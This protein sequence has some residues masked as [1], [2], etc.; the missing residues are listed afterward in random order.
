M[1]HQRKLIIHCVRLV[2]SY[3]T[4]ATLF[5]SSRCMSVWVCV[6]PPALRSL[7]EVGCLFPSFPNFTVNEPLFSFYNKR[8]M[9]TRI[10]T[11]IMITLHVCAVFSVNA[12]DVYSNITTDTTWT[13]AD[14][15]VSVHP[16]TFEIDEGIR[17]T[18]DEGVTVNFS[19]RV[20]VYGEL[21]VFGTMTNRITFNELTPDDGWGDFR[22]T[23]MSSPVLKTNILAYVDMQNM[24]SY[25]YLS[26][27]SL[28]MLGCTVSMVGN[29]SYGIHAYVNSDTPDPYGDATMSMISNVWNVTSTR[30]N[31]L[32]EC[33]AIHNEGCS[34]VLDGNTI[35]FTAVGV[36]GAAGAIYFDRN[37]VGPYYG[38]CFNNI[39]DVNATNELTRFAY[40][41]H[42]KNHINVSGIIS[43]NQITVHVPQSA[44]GI[45]KHDTNLIY[46]NTVS[47]QSWSSYSYGNI[48]GIN[49]YTPYADNETELIAKNQVSISAHSDERYVYGILYQ[50][51]KA[52]NNRVVIDRAGTG[53]RIRGIVQQ[54]Y[55]GVVEGNSICINSS[56]E[57]DTKG[58][59]LEGHPNPSSSVL[60]YNNIVMGSGLSNSYGIERSSGFVA[61]LSNDYNC[62]YNFSQNFANCT[63]GVHSV[64]G[65]P[66]FAD[67]ELHIQPGSVALDAGLNENWMLTARDFDGQ[68]RIDNNIVDI[69]ADEY[70]YQPSADITI[71]SNNQFS[72][73]WTTL[74]GALCRV[75]TCTNLMTGNWQY[76]TD[77]TNIVTGSTTTIFTN[78]LDQLHVRMERFF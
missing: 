52:R 11:L 56:N 36:L 65:N 19:G 39:I 62:V 22:L 58:L 75:Q 13:L 6:S 27:C 44:Y 77:M 24:G 18:V 8:Y 32:D 4:P 37:N 42:Y 45:D 72:A 40:G 70:F 49:A 30:S 54:I 20:L 63:A 33:Y 51:G 12:L 31:L 34:S 35:S 1:L 26:G 48:Y 43:N 21:Q 38:H 61:Q 67:A 71:T 15:P 66:M 73:N 28:E 64:T 29:L 10:A 74:T 25:M 78:Q 69:G 3:L 50:T 68:P 46:Q 17:L 57:V 41:I 55:S 60:V 16:Y 7:G 2:R 23:R 76:T 5:P 47:I 59:L 14:S 53:G 9:K